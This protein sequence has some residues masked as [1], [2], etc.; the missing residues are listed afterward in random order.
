M[1]DLS[2]PGAWVMVGDKQTERLD[3]LT[4][5]QKVKRR[6]VGVLLTGHSSAVTELLIS[7]LINAWKC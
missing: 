7:A 4:S 1:H 6:E 3:S 2:R 5:M